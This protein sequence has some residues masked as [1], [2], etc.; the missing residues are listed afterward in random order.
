MTKLLP[1]QKS[2]CP[3]SLCEN[4]ATL[5][6]IQELVRTRQGPRCYSLEL[7][8]LGVEMFSSGGLEYVY[9]SLSQSFSLGPSLVVIY[10]REMLNS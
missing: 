7:G 5:S 4:L 1:E 10:T 6:G 2:L 8:G 9:H 3:V